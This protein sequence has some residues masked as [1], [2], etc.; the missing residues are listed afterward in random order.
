MKK[1][2]IV[3]VG[4][5]ISGLS[6]G[7]HALQKSFD[8]EIY[9]SHHLVGG[10][11]TGWQRKG[12]SIDGCIHWFTGTKKGTP[13]YTLWETCGALS[14]HTQITHH[15]CIAS[16]I[17]ENRRVYHLYSDIQKMEAELLRISVLTYTQALCFNH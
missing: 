3:I 10:Q 4:A 11:C 2:K 14:E 13:L 12:Y 16:Y 9:E 7:I 5:G 15:E 1:R 6:A 8:V 17:D